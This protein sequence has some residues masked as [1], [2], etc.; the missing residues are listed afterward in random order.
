MFAL[1]VRLNVFVFLKCL[2]S[3]GLVRVLRFAMQW[4][5]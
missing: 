5:S 4:V 1:H 3:R 2:V